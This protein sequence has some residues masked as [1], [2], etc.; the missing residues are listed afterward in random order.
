MVVL[1]QS[2]ILSVGTGF[3]VR[4]VCLFRYVE[5]QRVRTPTRSRGSGFELE[6]EAVES[7]RQAAEEKQRREVVRYEGKDGRWQGYL[8]GIAVAAG[9]IVNHGCEK[10]IEK[11]AAN[12]LPPVRARAA[13]QLHL[14][15]R[16]AAKGALRQ[17]HRHVLAAKHAAARV[18]GRFFKSA[19]AAPKSPSSRLDSR[20]WNRQGRP[21]RRVE[22]GFENSVKELDMGS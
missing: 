7:H 6:K 22:H 14:W 1:P 9:K 5:S 20:S 3:H 18:P 13:R 15:N 19:H 12:L 8:N 16:L 4:A 10:Y 11:A 21:Y 17:V 2:V